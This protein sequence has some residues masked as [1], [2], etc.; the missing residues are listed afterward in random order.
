MLLL[1]SIFRYTV[2]MQRVSIVLHYKVVN[3][4]LTVMFSVFRVFGLFCRLVGG[5]YDWE[6][7][8]DEAVD[9]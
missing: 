5:V 6:H 2:D 1:V 8:D 7:D 4:V 3:I 9:A